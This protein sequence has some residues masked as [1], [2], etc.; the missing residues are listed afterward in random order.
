ML[1]GVRSG[2][3]FNRR[4]TVCGRRHGSSG[5]VRVVSFHAVAYPPRHEIH[6]RYSPA[7]LQDSYQPYRIFFLVAAGYG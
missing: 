7:G 5:H 4:S 3:F 1:V 2:R 6:G